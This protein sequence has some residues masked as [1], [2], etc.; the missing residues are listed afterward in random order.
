MYSFDPILELPPLESIYN[1]SKLQ[2]YVQ[3]NLASYIKEIGAGAAGVSVPSVSSVV[4]RRQKK[5]EDASWYSTSSFGSDEHYK[6]TFPH[7]PLAEF[8]SDTVC[9]FIYDA[10]CEFYKRIYWFVRDELPEDETVIVDVEFSGF[11][12]RRKATFRLTFSA[13]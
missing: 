2:Q 12:W 10:I 11:G 5:G 9:D 3:D 4:A 13:A 8:K 7:M 6:G 1:S